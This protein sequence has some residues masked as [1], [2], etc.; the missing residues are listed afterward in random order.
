MAL[1]AGAADAPPKKPGK[2]AN[3]LSR[4]LYVTDKIRISV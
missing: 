1:V 2:G 3:G 4:L